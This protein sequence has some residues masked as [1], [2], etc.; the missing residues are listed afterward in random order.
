MEFLPVELFD[1]RAA[2]HDVLHVAPEGELERYGIGEDH[3]FRVPLADDNDDDVQD[4][5]V[6]RRHLATE[7]RLLTPGPVWVVRRH[8]R[9]TFIESDPSHP[10]NPRYGFVVF[11][12]GLGGSEG[13]GDLRMGTG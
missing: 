1:V 8:R 7:L 13:P 10:M 5:F 11:L 12:R 9:W 3:A 2:R 4:L 6:V